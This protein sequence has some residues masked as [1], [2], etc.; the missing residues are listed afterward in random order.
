MSG[1][2]ITKTSGETWRDCVERIAGKCG[3]VS[4][5]LDLYDDAIKAGAL[6]EEAAFEALYEW[7]CCELVPDNGTGAAIL[8]PGA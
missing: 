3:L 4:E 1:L 8:P 2:Q 6:E 5:C 7:D